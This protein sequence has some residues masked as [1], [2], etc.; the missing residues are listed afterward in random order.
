M[1]IKMWQ[2][3]F[4][5]DSWVRKITESMPIPRFR[6]S[7]MFRYHKAKYYN[8]ERSKSPTC[9]VKLSPVLITAATWRDDLSG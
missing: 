8:L 2:H 9:G 7:I 3:D 1:N 5:A 4:K 6:P